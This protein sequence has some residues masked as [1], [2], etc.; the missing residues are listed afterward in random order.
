[1][2]TTLKTLALVALTTVTALPAAADTFLGARV[3]ADHSE[4]DVISV[5]GPTFFREVQFCVVNRAVH[6]RDVDVEFA[7]GGRQDL[8]VRVL[9]GPGQCTN[10]FNLRG[11]VRNI[12]QIRLRYD[13]LINAGSQAIVVARGR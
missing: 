1:M 8:P 12:D 6:F 7:N 9:V 13:T 2:K 3:V 10:W 11:P 4:T 5:P